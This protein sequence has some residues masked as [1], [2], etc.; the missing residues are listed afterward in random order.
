MDGEIWK[1]RGPSLFSG[2]VLVCTFQYSASFFSFLEGLLI[3]QG[4]DPETAHHPPTR[5][6]FS[7]ASRAR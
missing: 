5:S 2:D 6:L 7:S 4:S 3:A 1:P